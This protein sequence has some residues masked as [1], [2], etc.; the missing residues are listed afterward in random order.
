MEQWDIN[1]NRCGKFILTEQRDDN[2]RISHI[3][4]CYEDGYYDQYDDEFYCNDCSKI[5]GINKR[6]GKTSSE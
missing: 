3:A 2:G 5:L 4:G 1:C 6:N